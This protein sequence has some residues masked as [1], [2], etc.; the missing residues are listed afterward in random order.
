LWV[1]GCE[2]WVQ[3]QG[4]TCAESSCG[5]TRSLLRTR[6]GGEERRGDGGGGGSGG[7]DGDGRKDGSAKGG[8]GAPPSFL[9]E[10]RGVPERGGGERQD[11]LRES[12]SAAHHQTMALGGD[13]APVRFHAKHGGV[14]RVAGESGRRHD[15][16]TRRGRDGRER[17]GRQA[18]NI[19]H[20]SR[21]IAARAR[22]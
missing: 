17:D 3:G 5:A 18:L 1:V 4:W 10:T 9:R 19:Y 6:S 16:G 12:H 8:G 2:L 13:R 11:I 14:A 20:G 15:W 22:A 7:S 21:A